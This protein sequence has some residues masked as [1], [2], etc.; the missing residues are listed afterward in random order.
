M[1]YFIDG[2]QG[3][4]Q[5]Y[6]SLQR[7]KTFHEAE[8]LARIKDVITAHQWVQKKKTISARES[9]RTNQWCANWKPS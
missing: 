7:P 8:S 2:L 4:L 3:D 9:A 5:T 6:V 1:R